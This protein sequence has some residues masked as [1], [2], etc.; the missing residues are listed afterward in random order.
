MNKPINSSANEVR[1]G[2]L[3]GQDGQSTLSY[4]MTCVSC[5]VIK[6]LVAPKE[7]GWP[8]GPPMP[9]SA[10]VSQVRNLTPNFTI[11]TLI[12][13]AYSPKIAEIGNVCYKFAQKGYIPLSVI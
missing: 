12:M 4:S 1:A 8:P 5:V 2:P 6:I 10:T 7:G 13:W 11:V 9:I 3:F